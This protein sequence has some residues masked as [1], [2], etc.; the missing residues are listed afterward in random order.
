MNPRLSYRKSSQFAPIFGEI[1]VFSLS[2]IPSHKFDLAFN[3][4]QAEHE[5]DNW[6]GETAAAAMKFPSWLS[7]H[8]HFFLQR[9]TF[10]TAEL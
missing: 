7:S 4:D 3:K 5:G 6:I 10:G 8:F 1:D 9:K 2:L